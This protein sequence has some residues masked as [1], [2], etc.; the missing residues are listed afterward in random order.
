MRWGGCSRLSE[1]ENV[2]GLVLMSLKKM[3]MGMTD[4]E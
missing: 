2:Q 1:E 3:Y 4:F